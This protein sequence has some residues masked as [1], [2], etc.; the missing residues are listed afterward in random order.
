L[1]AAAIALGA[2]CGCAGPSAGE[3]SSSARAQVELTVF[4][5]ASLKGAMD[6]AA[7]AYAAANPAISLTYSVDSS[8]A[9]A[10]QIE[11]G[12]PVDVFLSA[13]TVNPARLA[14]AGLAAGAPVAFAGNELV[15]AVAPENP[16]GIATAFDLARPGVRVVAAADEVP[17]AA[18]AA[19]LVRNLAALPGAPAGF[20]AGYAANIRS[21][22][23][24]FKAVL[25]KIELG[26]GDAGIVYATDV[27]SSTVSTIAVEPAAAN[28]RATYAGVVV[29]ASTRQAAARAFLD[30]LAGPDG[31]AVLAAFG[32][33]P[34]P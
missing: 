18:Y 33:L 3:A 16:A 11:Q 8:A 34:A 26:E 23:L 1:L 10:T 27:P 4:A 30:W 29:G 22:E 28:V 9:L 20:A 19:D 24:N 14:A 31:Q 5:A 15:I 2:A 25:A 21:K 17:I 6:A 13:D 12:A 32:F 7:T